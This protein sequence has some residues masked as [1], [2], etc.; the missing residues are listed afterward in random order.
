MYLLSRKME[1][2]MGRLRFF[3]RVVPNFFKH[4]LILSN[5]PICQSNPVT[6][7]LYCNNSD[8][9]VAL[10]SQQCV[11][12]TTLQGAKKKSQESIRVD[13]TP[14]F[15]AKDSSFVQLMFQPLRSRTRYPSL[16][17]DGSANERFNSGTGKQESAGK[18]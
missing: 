18:E 12:F 15:G 11:F 1:V 13:G 2:G 7:R 10:K 14:K 8:M 5:Q 4:S 16:A 17:V 6:L 9:T 3:L